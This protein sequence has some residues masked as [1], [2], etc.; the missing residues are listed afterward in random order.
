VRRLALVTTFLLFA[1]NSA[2]GGDDVPPPKPKPD[3]GID[4]DEGLEEDTNLEDF[5]PDDTAVDDTAIDDTGS[6]VDTSIDDTM[7]DDALA[8]GD[9]GPPCHPIINELETGT[10]AT[11]TDEF[12][13]IYNPCKKSVNL[14]GWKIVYRAEKNLNSVD[15]PDTNT[16]VVIGALTI[17]SGGYMM[18]ANS[19]GAYTALTYKPDGTYGGGL[20]A[21]AGS[22][23]LRDVTGKLVDSVFY[24]T[25]AGGFHAFIETKE[26]TEP[27]TTAFPG[28]SIA[29]SP[30]GFDSDDNSK[31]F[32]SFTP[33]TPRAKNP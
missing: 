15:G 27:P 2:Q 7:V 17:I 30:N 16:L 18:W 21:T 8:D 26:V 31:D 32:K 23:G 20:P 12:I 11:A 19:G 4:P 14:N 3:F 28:Y 22:V 10:T 24:G 29:R 1:C 5:G 33:P 25:P 13:E 9:T 6:L